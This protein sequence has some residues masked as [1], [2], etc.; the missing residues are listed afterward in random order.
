MLPLGSVVDKGLVT[1]STKRTPP[2]VVVV[3]GARNP[4]VMFQRA[5]CLECTKRFRSQGAADAHRNKTEH[6]VVE[7]MGWTVH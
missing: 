1:M 6:V 4:P 5:E 7:V 3:R 2:P